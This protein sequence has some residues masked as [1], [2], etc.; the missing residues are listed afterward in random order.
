M[1]TNIELDDQLVRRALQIS[2]TKN[3]KKKWFMRL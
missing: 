3:Q 2:N 1:R